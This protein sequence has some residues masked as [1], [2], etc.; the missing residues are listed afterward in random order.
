MK[1]K[2]LT[3]SIILIMIIFVSLSGCIN[4]SNNK[5]IIDPLT[6]RPPAPSLPIPPIIN[7]PNNFTVPSAPFVPQPP[8]PTP[9]I[10]PPDIDK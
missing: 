8:Q 10:I 1:K 2:I 6:T 3:F 4:S 5:S 7:P 9:F